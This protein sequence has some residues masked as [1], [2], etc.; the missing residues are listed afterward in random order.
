[1]YLYFYFILH[2]IF[3]IF[4]YHFRETLFQFH[5]HPYTELTIKLILNLESKKRAHKVLRSVNGIFL[6]L[7]VH[8]LISLC[9]H[10]SDIKH[11]VVTVASVGNV[12][13]DT[14]ENPSILLPYTCHLENPHWQESVSV[15]E[16]RKESQHSSTSNYN[17]Q[18]SMLI[19]KKQSNTSPKSVLNTITHYFTVFTTI[20]FLLLLANSNYALAR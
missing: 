9:F 2:L 16:G 6:Q 14:A 13:G 15:Q 18:H 11:S 1:M 8:A 3:N 5:V 17:V 7:H 12:G 10:T 4:I 19:K 20:L